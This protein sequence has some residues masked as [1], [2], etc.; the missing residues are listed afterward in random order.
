MKDAV[1]ILNFR[2]KSGTVY[3]FHVY[4]LPYSPSMRKGG[5]YLFT[6]FLDNDFHVPVFLGITEDLKTFFSNPDE[7]KSIRKSD[8]THVCVCI[9][10]DG[11]KREF[12]EEDLSELAQTRLYVQTQ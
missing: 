9:E 5:I 10:E 4:A 11:S 2:G 1:N 12:A 3:K 8:P 6:K 7:M